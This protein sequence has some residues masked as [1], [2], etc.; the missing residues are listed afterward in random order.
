MRYSLQETKR[1]GFTYYEIIDTEDNCKVLYYSR[2]YE[3]ISQFMNWME[4][5]K[6]MPIYYNGKKL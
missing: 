4:R 3:Q 6:D 1:S 2:D 5:N